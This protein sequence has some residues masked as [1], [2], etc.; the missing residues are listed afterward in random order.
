MVGGAIT[1]PAATTEPDDKTWRVSGVALQAGSGVGAALRP[2]RIPGKRFDRLNHQ[3][4]ASPVRD[5]V[6]RIWREKRTASRAVLFFAVFPIETKVYN[7]N[8]KEHQP[9]PPSL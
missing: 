4:S 1:D 2:I 3:I 8:R 9:C 5:G 7:E 6:S